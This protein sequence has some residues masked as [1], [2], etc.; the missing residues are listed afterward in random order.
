MKKNTTD[1][2][3]SVN[4]AANFNLYILIC[5]V[6]YI[7]SFNCTRTKKKCCIEVLMISQRVIIIL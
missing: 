5:S 4:T 1:N 2:P 6:I 3:T 7:L